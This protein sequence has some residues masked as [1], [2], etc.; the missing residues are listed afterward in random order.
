MFFNPIINM[1]KIFFAITSLG[2]LSLVNCNGQKKINTSF[3]PTSRIRDIQITLTVNRSDFSYNFKFYNESNEDILIVKP[4]PHGV[5]SS[6]KLFDSSS[7]IVGRKCA[8]IDY[9][10]P[11]H[12]L[13]L[14]AKNSITIEGDVSLRDLF[15]KIEDTNLLGF[16][17]R[18]SYE[19]GSGN[20]KEEGYFDF[21]ILP[22]QIKKLDSVV[23][24][25]RLF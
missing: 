8:K 4:R 15:C 13:K 5:F 17:Y 6:F 16:F 25:K 9:S 24:N 19:V 10:A 3:N 21:E 11:I 12:F 14:P 2:I 1:K 22:T 7:T 20:N 23:I 18:G